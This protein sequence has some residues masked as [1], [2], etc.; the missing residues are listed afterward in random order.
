MRALDYISVAIQQKSLFS[1]KILNVS[2]ERSAAPCVWGTQMST[3]TVWLC[4][5]GSFP[6][7]SSPDDREVVFSSL[8]EGLSVFHG[9]PWAGQGLRGEW[10]TRADRIRCAGVVG[11]RRGRIGW[12]FRIIPKLWVFLWLYLAFFS[13]YRSFARPRVGQAPMPQGPGATG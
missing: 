7:S 9:P 1:A 8:A 4:A 6:E 11:W 12:S 13:S 2:C 10:W 3:W 5:C